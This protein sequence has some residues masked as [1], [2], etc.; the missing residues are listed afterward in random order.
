M[1]QR[2][3][4]AQA[5]TGDITIRMDTATRARLDALAKR[6]GLST[7]ALLRSL[8]LEEAERQ[9]LAERILR[10]LDRAGKGRSAK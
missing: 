2:M 8:G 3:A 9:G 7:G 6:R 10:Q 1:M 4:R 5:K